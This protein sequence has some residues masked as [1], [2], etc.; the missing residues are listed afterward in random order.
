M[1]LITPAPS[2]TK[3]PENIG[4]DSK[5]ASA[6]Y[7]TSLVDPREY[8][9]GAILTNIQGNPLRVDYYSQI[10]GLDESPAQYDPGQSAVY[11]QYLHIT[12][13]EIRQQGSLAASNDPVTNELSLQGTAIMYP[14]LIPNRGD[15]I[16]TDIGDGR[17]GIFGVIDTNQYTLFKQ[18]AY[19]ITF[20]L[21]RYLT[22]LEKNDLRQKTVEEYIFRKDFITYGRYP[23]ITREEEVQQKSLEASIVTLRQTFLH[24]FY[25]A[26]NRCIMV[27][28]QEAPAYDPYLARAFLRIV[29]VDDDP[30]IGRIQ[31]LNCDDYG[32][33]DIRSA[34][35]LLLEC[36]DQLRGLDFRKIALCS[37]GIFT[38]NALLRSVRWSGAKY[39]IVPQDEPENVDFEFK[40]LP[41]ATTG[42]FPNT[43]TRTTVLDVG[44][45][46][47]YLFSQWFYSRDRPKMTALEVMV[48]RY[49]LGEPNT[50]S[51][52]SAL[53]SQL[54]T[55]PLLT[56]AY[57]IP[58][59]MILLI[60]E[61]KRG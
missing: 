48:D 21:I 16:L 42:F 13:F 32:Y 1:P 30:R 45:D 46:E 27:P 53:T 40:D 50:A 49:L 23:F 36:D 57:A 28:G 22:E 10:L 31:L 55:A 8:P 5:I 24:H 60:A 35:D 34:W 61:A 58:V 3:P 17:A 20:K 59:A 47:D 15:V 44:V 51:E 54:L 6:S 18:S 41:M 37:V 38:P 29:N 52:L 9:R 39:V 25:S 2:N 26:N 56:K 4:A 33:R 7:R 11:Q 14:G 12:N 19:E 43:S